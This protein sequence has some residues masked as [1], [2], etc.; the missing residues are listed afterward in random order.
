M[1]IVTRRPCASRSF[2]Y[3]VRFPVQWQYSATETMYHMHSELPICTQVIV[4]DW[5]LNGGLPMF[6]LITPSVF[7]YLN[8][9]HSTKPAPWFWFYLQSFHRRRCESSFVQ[10]LDCNHPVIHVCNNCSKPLFLPV[11]LHVTWFLVCILSSVARLR[12]NLS[13]VDH[14]FSDFA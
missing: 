11:K 7:F 10:F 8:F 6:F 12:L 3:S 5:C 13:I 1:W 14:P 9:S 4:L 2:P